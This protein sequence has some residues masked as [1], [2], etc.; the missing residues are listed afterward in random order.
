MSRHGFSGEINDL[1][2]SKTELECVVE[3]LKASAE[4]TGGKREEIENE[5]DQV[6]NEIMQKEQSL[7][8]FLPLYEQQR[9]QESEEKHKYVI[10]L[11]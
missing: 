6:R 9:A 7:N 5:L 3:D 8:S 11:K 2:K 1:V 10:L 4:R